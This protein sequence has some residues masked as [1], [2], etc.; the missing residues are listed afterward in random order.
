MEPIRRYDAV[1]SAG[2]PPRIPVA[3][4][5]VGV[6]FAV[7]LAL[8]VFDAA[9]SWWAVEARGYATE[10]NGLLAGVANAIG[11][12]PTMAVRAVWGVAG[13]SAVW[14]IW[15]RWRSPAAAWGLVVVASV[16]SLVAGWHL[17]GPLVNLLYDIPR[18]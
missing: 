14:L 11:F 17:I 8:T 4:T 18:I 2:R 5:A 3:P 13:V 16:M 6:A 10:A 12:G 15:R 9:A 7:A 1:P